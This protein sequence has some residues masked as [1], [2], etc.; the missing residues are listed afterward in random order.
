MRPD[1]LTST[2]LH[3]DCVDMCRTL[4]AESIDLVVTSPPY[5]NIRNYDGAWYDFEGLASELYRVLRPSGVIFWNEAGEC[6]GATESIL[7]MVHAVHFVNRFGMKLDIHHWAKMS[8][9]VGRFPLPFRRHEFCFVLSKGDWRTI[10]KLEYERSEGTLRRSESLAKNARI[11]RSSGDELKRENKTYKVN[12]KE[13]AV[14]LG[15]V[16]ILPNASTEAGNKDRELEHP[17]TMAKE[18]AIRAV[19][20]WSNP[21][22]TVLDPFGGSGTTAWAA[23]GQGRHTVAIEKSA[24]FIKMI[25]ASVAKARGLWGLLSDT[26]H[27]PLAPTVKKR[28][29]WG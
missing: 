19:H 5:G 3:G 9:M 12:T 26:E 7:P 16:W 24:K 20:V 6:K 17:A 8:G 10:N 13:D 2:I 1:E 25:E 28:E 27:A 14:T 18:V 4:D 22:D 29:V 15:N 21:G 11:S 23:I